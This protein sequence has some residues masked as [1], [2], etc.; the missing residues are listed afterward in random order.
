MAPFFVG[1]KGGKCVA[2]S[3]PTPIQTFPGG[4]ALSL[5]AEAPKGACGS[6]GVLLFGR[7]CVL[8]YF[9][10][11]LL[12]TAAGWRLAAG[13]RSRVMWYSDQLSFSL[14]RREPCGP[15]STIRIL[16]PVLRAN[17]PACS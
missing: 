17:T 3:F 1:S 10:G 5:R 14:R 9:L 11:A 4:K 15:S 13:Y 6:G 12:R 16:V 2:F 8:G 7:R